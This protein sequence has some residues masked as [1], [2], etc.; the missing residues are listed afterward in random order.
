MIRFFRIVLLLMG[1]LLY[2]TI[3]VRMVQ[4][5]NP[6]QTYIVIVGNRPGGLCCYTYMVNPVKNEAHR[7]RLSVIEQPVA[8]SSISPSGRWRYAHVST[9]T[10]RLVYLIR[11]DDDGFLRL[12][13]DVGQGRYVHW[14][15]TRDILYFIGRGPASA[16]ALH[17]LTPQN[18]DPVRLTSYLFEDVR[19]IHQQ[20][21]PHLPDFAPWLLVVWAINVLVL[22]GALRPKS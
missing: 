12:P 18:P 13:E 15:A 17:R 22:A 5:S 16:A 7:V 4:P 19:A 3:T 9:Q 21:I 14:D 11:L 20:P 1:L 8:T 6:V 2:A 10:G